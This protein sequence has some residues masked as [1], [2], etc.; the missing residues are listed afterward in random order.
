MSPRY[1]PLSLPAFRP[2]PQPSPRPLL[3]SRYAHTNPLFRL[4]WLQALAAALPE[5]LRSTLIWT[6]MQPVRFQGIPAVQSRERLRLPP[7]VLCYLPA[8]RL[9]GITRIELAIGRRIVEVPRTEITR[10]MR[11]TLL[12]D[13]GSYLAQVYYALVAQLGEANAQAVFAKH[14][15]AL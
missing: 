10:E 7:D 2:Q 3:V 9:D 1:R 15:E 4:F 14:I 11:G 12:R 13:Q 6:W 5:P 8:W